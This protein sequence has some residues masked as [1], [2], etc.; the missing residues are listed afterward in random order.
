MTG[1]VPAQPLDLRRFS[2]SQSIVHGIHALDLR[3]SRGSQFIVHSIN[4]LS[5]DNAGL[6]DVT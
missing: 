1:S 6:A 5:S 4:A 3:F 2:V